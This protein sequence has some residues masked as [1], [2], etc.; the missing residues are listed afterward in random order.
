M[1]DNKQNLYNFVTYNLHGLNNGRSGLVDLCN[2]PQ[3]LVIAIQEHWL[4]N[5]N[6]YLLNNIHPD[7]IGFGISAMS[8]RLSSE[9]YRGRPYGG[10]GFLWRKT[11]SGRIHIDHKSISGR[12]L[13][14]LLQLDSVRSISIIDVYFP[15][16]VSGVGYNAEL[17]ECLSFIEDVI[18]DGH[19]VI[20]LGDTNF[21]CDVNNAGYRQCLDLLSSYN[22]SNCDNFISDDSPVTYCN[23]KLEHFSFIDHVFVSNS[24]RPNIVSAVIYNSGVNLSDHIPLIYTFHFDFAPQ[25]GTIKPQGANSPITKH[26]SWRWDK[27]DLGYYYEC[28][29]NNLQNIAQ[30]VTCNNCHIGCNELAHLHSIDIFYEDIVYA[31]HHASTKAVQRMPCHSLKP[32]WNDELDRLK[33][34]SIFW[35]NLWVDAGRPSSGVL[36]RIRLSC[37][38]KYKLAIRNAYVSFEDK[39]SDEL[40]FHYSNKN[41]PD[42]WKTWNA[43]FRK[44][45]VKQVHI[46]GCNNDGDV[47]NV[48]ASHFQSVFY[49]SDDDQSAKYS[50]LHKRDE[51]IKNGL[52]SSIECI[53]KITVELIDRCIKKLKLGK[54]CGPDD[55]C[56]EHLLYAHPILIMQLKTLFQLIL[57]HGYVPNSFGFGVS[58]PLVKD[59]AGNI[60][61]VDNYRAITLSPVIS[62][63]FE[64]VLLSICDDSL[65]TDPLQFGFKENVGCSEA[66]F[67]LK[68]TIGYFIDRGSPV[69]V[70]SLDISKAFDK[71]NHYK[72]YESLLSA[73]VP[74]IIVDIVCNWYSKLFVAIRWNGAL[75]EQFSVGSGVRQGSC[76]SPRIFTVFVNMFIVQL[77]YQNIGC[78]VLSMFFGCLF[79]ADDII[80][81][82]PT[83][84]GLQLMLNKC[85]E[86]A[87]LLALQ[88]NVNKSCCIA[89]GKT[90][91]VKITAMTLGDKLIEWSTTVK[92]LG[93]YLLS[94]KKLKFDINPIKRNFYAACNSIFM[95]T[96]GVDDIALLSLQESHSLSVLMYAAPALTLGSRQIDELNVCWNSVIRKIFGYHRWESVKC[97]LYGLGR[98]NVKHLILLRKVKF[99]W[100]LYSMDTCNNMLHN[101]FCVYLQNNYCHDDVAKTVFLPRTLAVTSVWKRFENYVN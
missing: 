64:M 20:I 58:V 15:C 90:C 29:N 79:Y 53:D 28:T 49:N 78:N 46:N 93:V 56:S 9:V 75:S 68:S 8:S 99:Y 13:S 43:R 35:H 51:C 7:F 65:V 69:Y 67:T 45:I 12:C 94:C 60:N 76:L 86:V 101:L 10:V 1:A 83:V 21:Q 4:T 32:Y 70:A 92:Y 52:Q 87:G 30:P 41:M 6:M 14:I 5:D 71:V 31:L 50:Y 25:N 33:E 81:L 72:M 74:M 16:F 11:F 37:R 47:A 100:R 55:L 59:K 96:K 84:N 95:H 26:Y 36:Q 24:V 98:L 66:I 39:L 61:N 22:I 54:A 2:N 57:V 42:F 80:L 77:K 85:N 88:F 73:G 18:S 23:D 38:A 62:K 19:E 44:N 63:L 40:C 48:F 34:D 27:S 3:T 82:C 89:I 17:A 97:V 91:N